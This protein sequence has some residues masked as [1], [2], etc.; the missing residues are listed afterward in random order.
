MCAGAMYW[1]NI[2]NVVFGHSATDLAMLLQD[3]AQENEM[4][5]AMS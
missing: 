3:D 2:R 5:I 1:A 4:G